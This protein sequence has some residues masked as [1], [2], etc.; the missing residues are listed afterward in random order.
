MRRRLTYPAL[1]GALYAALT[2]LLAP[3]S[4]GAIQLRAAEALC[5]LPFFLPETAF[6]LAL[7]C[8]IA[9]TLSAAGLPDIVFGSL[10]TLCA[11]LCTAALGK[12]VRKSGKAPSLPRSLAAVLMPVVWNGVT[13]GAVLAFTLTRPA[14][15]QGFLLMAAQ[16]ALGECAVML[17]LGL[18]LLRAVPKLLPLH[19]ENK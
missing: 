13:V 17:L 7:G 5:V 16:V 6:G 8:A 9:N 11:G 1:A 14:F 18:P 19:N 10:A 4:Y 12:A 2:M 15:L 3:I